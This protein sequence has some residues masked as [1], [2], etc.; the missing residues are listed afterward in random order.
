MKTEKF[1]IG[2]FGYLYFYIKFA[3]LPI[4]DIEV[5]NNEFIFNNKRNEVV[6]SFI[7]IISRYVLPLNKKIQMSNQNFIESVFSDTSSKIN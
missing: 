6:S 3:Y 7:L 5:I 1:R 2:I 4:N